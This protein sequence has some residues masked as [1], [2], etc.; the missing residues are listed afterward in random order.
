MTWGLMHLECIQRV[1]SACLASEWL[2]A[3]LDLH[4][5]TQGSH[6]QEKEG[7]KGSG[8]QVGDVSTAVYHSRDPKHT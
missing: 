1:K 2:S 8:E 4:R 6:R 7:V 3:H 5:A